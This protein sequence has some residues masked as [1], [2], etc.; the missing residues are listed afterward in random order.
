MPENDKKN[1]NSGI[2]NRIRVKNNK[3]S[4]CNLIE[5]I[6]KILYLTVHCNS[7]QL[8]QLLKSTCLRNVH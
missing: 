7:K 6:K 5:S 3:I 8:E 1:R 4:T 2:E